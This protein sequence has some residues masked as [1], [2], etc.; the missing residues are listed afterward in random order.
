MRDSTKVTKSTFEI[1]KT[2]AMGTCCE[3][4]CGMSILVD[5]SDQEGGRQVRCTACL[6]RVKTGIKPTR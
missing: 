2:L 1:D 5:K 6:M 3:P 4:D